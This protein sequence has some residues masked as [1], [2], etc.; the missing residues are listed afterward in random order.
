MPTL[1]DFYE[2]CHPLFGVLRL[3]HLQQNAL[4]DWMQKLPPHPAEENATTESHPFNVTYYATGIGEV[5]I[6]WTNINDEEYSIHLEYDDDGE[7]VK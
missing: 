2:C 7:M 6:V 1:Q 3:D 5:F 4:W